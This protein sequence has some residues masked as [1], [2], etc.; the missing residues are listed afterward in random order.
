MYVRAHKEQANADAA[1]PL[2]C[3]VMSMSSTDRHGHG[4]KGKAA[5]LPADVCH[6][7]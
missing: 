7:D 1:C 3:H 6:V 4:P 2:P 5:Q